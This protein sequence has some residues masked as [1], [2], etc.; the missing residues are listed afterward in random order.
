MSEHRLLGGRYRLDSV[1]GRGGMS[2]VWRSYDVM[3]GREVAVKEVVPPPGLPPAERDRLHERTLREA[4]ASAR[5]AHPGVVAVYDV[6]E[7]YGQAWI[8]T[9]MVR[10]RSLQDILDEEGP[11][12][13]RRVAE[14]GRRLAA[15]LRHAHEHG[16]LHRD[17]KPANVLITGDGRVLL[18]EFLSAVF[19]VDAGLAQTGMLV[20]SPDYVAPERV[21]GE[22]AAAASDLWSL[23]AT[24][25]AALEGHPPFRRSDVLSTLAAVVSE[26]LPPARNAGPLGPVL[27]GL[28]AREPGQRLTA[29][30]AE[31]MLS[32]IAG[33]QEQPP[34][35]GQPQP[36]Q[37]PQTQ[38]PFPSAPMHARTLGARPLAWGS[39]SAVLALLC[40]VLWVVTST[41]T[42]ALRALAGAV[43][44]VLIVVAGMGAGRAGVRAVRRRS[45]EQVEALRPADGAFDLLSQGRFAEAEWMLRTMASDRGPHVDR[46]E[47]GANLAIAQRGLGRVSDAERT[48]TAA[49][50]QAGGHAARS[51]AVATI[52]QAG[53]E[54]IRH[55]RG[56]PDACD[57]L[58]EILDNADP[59]DLPA[60]V[61]VS[62]RSDLAVACR[63]RNRL[64]EAERH[65]R[66]ALADAER[67]LDGSSPTTLSAR[68]NLAAIRRDRGHA[69]EAGD[70]YRTLLEDAR[71][72]LGR[73]HPHTLTIQAGL[74]AVHHDLGE[75]GA[76]EGL[77]R[78]VVRARSQALGPSHPATLQARVNLGFLHLSAGERA[79]AER[80]FEEVVA[81]RD[82]PAAADAAAVVDE[83]AEGL[84]AARGRER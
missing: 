10:A 44:I 32:A 43:V 30:Q 69:A 7:G 51:S 60:R 75:H 57:R 63:D 58:A 52:L 81:A 33:Y 9:E 20:A 31:A 24:L 14:I 67:E 62:L 36:W 45:A 78:D 68:A 71:H 15:V 26:P 47:A 19:E 76:A 23:G 70:L 12:G 49:S 59:A 25:Y 64:D 5:L 46:V 48:L 56:D 84:A 83:A 35:Q 4:R 80:L 55:E 29:V 74:A 54:A 18:T 16:V 41:N 38:A 17:V 61:R 40:A 2:T 66:A 65:I 6:L 77:L 8:V 21:Q 73:R 3:L 42:A 34:Q 22:P 27:E 53:L 37:Q 79:A 82:D 50:S 13:H 72:H 11:L 39:F 28:L 1:V